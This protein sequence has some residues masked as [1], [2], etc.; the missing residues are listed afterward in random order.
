MFASRQ[1]SLRSRR[2][3]SIDSLQ[4]EFTPAGLLQ[5]KE[6]A[7]AT[8]TGMTITMGQTF[9]SFMNAGSKTTASCGDADPST[10]A[11]PVA[12]TANAPATKPWKL[13]ELD[14]VNSRITL[15]DLGVG[16]HERR[17]QYRDHLERHPAF[18]RR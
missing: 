12:T 4:I 15:A 2:S 6:I 7:A 8:L 17:L 13:R 1:P 16:A 14:I 9:R 5:R 18:R 3:P 10:A 11:T